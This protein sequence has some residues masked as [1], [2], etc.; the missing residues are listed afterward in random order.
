MN[1]AELRICFASEEEALLVAKAV[2]L[3]NLGYV[4]MEVEKNE[5]I[6]SAQAENLLSLLHT[7]DDFLACA[8]LALRARNLTKARQP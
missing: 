5:I 4:E 1:R 8:T 3:E 7:L 6:A 2:E